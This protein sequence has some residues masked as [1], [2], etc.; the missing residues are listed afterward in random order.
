[1]I[2]EKII[3]NRTPKSKLDDSITFFFEITT[4]DPLSAIKL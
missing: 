4:V 2:I 3:P 1:M